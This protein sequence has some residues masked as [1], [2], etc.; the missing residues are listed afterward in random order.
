MVKTCP[1]KQSSYHA[2]ARVRV[3]LGTTTRS[4][5]GTHT[6]TSTWIE[7]S[8]ACN[9]LGD[10]VVA[11]HRLIS[12]RWSLEPATDICSRLPRPPERPF[13]GVLTREAPA[14]VWTGT[15]LILWSGGTGGDGVP[16]PNDGVAFRPTP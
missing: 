13:E 11:G 3:T 12:D 9:T 6:A 4:T 10:T 8:G 15:E 14:A 2:S 5:R 7:R 1:F 16:P